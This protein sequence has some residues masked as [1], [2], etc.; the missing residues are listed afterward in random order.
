MSATMTTEPE[1]SELVPL[2]DGPVSTVLAG[3]HAPTGEA[4]ALKVLPGRLDRRTRA[5]LETELARLSTLREHAAI[6]VADRVEDLGDGRYALRMELCT[7]SLPELLASFGPLSVRDTLA[8]GTALAEALSAAH[9]AGILHGGVTPGNVLFR[10]SGEPVL[11]DFGLT[12]RHAFPADPLRTVDFVPPETVRDGSVD[13]RSDL[14]GLGAILYLAL[15]NRSPHQGPPGEQQGDHLLRVLGTPVPPLHRADLPPGLAELVSEL[16]AKDPQARP[17]DAAMV[18]GRLDALYAAIVPPDEPADEPTAEPSFDDFAASRA[19]EAEP[20]RPAPRPQGEP[21]LVFGPKQPLRRLPR[22]SVLAGAGA[23][24]LLAVVAVLLLLNRPDELTVPTA[25]PP[26]A[27]S[28]VAPTSTRAAVRLE[29]TDPTDRGNFV[30]LSWRSSEPLDFAV[31][32]AG[33]GEQAKTLFAHRNT[34]FRV[35]VDPVRKYCFL[36]QATNGQE[37]YSSAPKSI[38]GASCVQ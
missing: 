28:T 7:Q 6:L 5:G 13:E 2:G 11:G 38:R 37:V 19:S 18:A 30:E 20:E 24:S 14:Y 33:E 22:P 35:P 10:P 31:I 29:L 9:G 4:F 3:V 34:S 17:V 15:S 23:L 21:I 8:L 32:V 25:P 1:Y 26:V 27:T 16:L 12:L 36:I